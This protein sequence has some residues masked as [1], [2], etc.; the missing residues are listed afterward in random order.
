VLETYAYDAFGKASVYD[1][2]FNLLP[3]SLQNNRFLFTGREYIAEAGIYD[4]RNRAYSPELGRFLQT[5][6]IRFSA[7]D[8]NLYRYVANNTVNAVDPSGQSPWDTAENIADSITEGVASLGQGL[9]QLLYLIPCI[10]A[11]STLIGCLAEQ[12]SN[13][14]HDCSKEEANKE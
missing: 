2:S 4:Y 8:A 14:C 11:R 5:D 1:S 3:S 9:L 13:P 6:P 10:N 12:D 7:G